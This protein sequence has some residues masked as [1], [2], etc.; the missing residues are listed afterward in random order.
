MDKLFW[1]KLV[2]DQPKC[3]QCLDF[4]GLYQSWSGL[5][6]VFF[7]RFGILMS[8]HDFSFGLLLYKRAFYNKKAHLIGFGLVYSVYLEFTVCCW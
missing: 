1:V 7:P 8:F 4:L 2:A 6:W 5:I 3:S